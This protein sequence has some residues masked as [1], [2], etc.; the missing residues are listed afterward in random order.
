MIRNKLIT[1][2]LLCFMAS[3]KRLTFEGKTSNAIKVKTD[4][5]F[6][7]H[8]PEDHSKGINWQLDDSYDKN[9]LDYTNSVWEGNSRGV[10]FLFK[11]TKTGA[12]KL[13]FKE[14][15]FNEFTDSVFVTVAVE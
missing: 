12:T 6:S 15:T 9:I 11:A 5:K 14:R 3:C 7:L 8:F 13:L 1:I 10:N 4:E 2:V